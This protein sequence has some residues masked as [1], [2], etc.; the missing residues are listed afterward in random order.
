MYTNERCDL[1]SGREHRNR[2]LIRLVHSMSNEI[3]ALMQAKYGLLPEV[4]LNEVIIN[5]THIARSMREVLQEEEG[6]ELHGRAKAT[7]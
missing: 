6:V 3:M 2:E 1:C 7:G 4:Q 5:M